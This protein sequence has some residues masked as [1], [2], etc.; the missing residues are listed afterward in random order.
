MSR[1]LKF[2]DR[3]PRGFKYGDWVSRGFKC[4]DWVPKGLKGKNLCSEK[5]VSRRRTGQRER[6]LRKNPAEEVVKYLT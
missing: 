4:G 5:G 2:T 3:V 6:T 1:G